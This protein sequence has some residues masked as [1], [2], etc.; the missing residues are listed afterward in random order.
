MEMTAILRDLGQ[1]AL[2]AS[3][4]DIPI[5]GRTTTTADDDA[6]AVA[7]LLQHACVDPGST[8]SRRMVAA[9]MRA[10]NASLGE[11]RLAYACS[12]GS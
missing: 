1:S 2:S 8:Q 7:T 10:A 6:L 9:A 4:A 11:A 5:G 12:P 3:R